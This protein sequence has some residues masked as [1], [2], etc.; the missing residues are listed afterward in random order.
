MHDMLTWV[1][2]WNTQ[3][4][5]S[6]VTY[7][8]GEKFV[9]TADV[10]LYAI[11]A[12]YEM[13][14]TGDVQ[15]F[16]TPRDGVYRLEVW[17]AEGGGS[18]P[19]K[20]GYSTTL[21]HLAEG[22]SFYVYVGEKPAN[23]T[24]IAGG[25][26]GGGSMGNNFNNRN[27]AGAGGGATDFRLYTDANDTNKGN[28]VIDPAPQAEPWK[29]LSGDP[30]TDPRILVAGGG[31]GS[32]QTGSSVLRIGGAGG[33]EVGQSSYGGTAS[34]YATGGTQT[35]GGN[36]Y[37]GYTIAANGEPGQ[38]SDG[39]ASNGFCRTGG[40]GGSGWWGGAGGGNSWSGVAD[41]PGGGGGSG[42]AG[43]TGQTIAGHDATGIPKISTHKGVDTGHAGHGYARIT[44]LGD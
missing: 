17:G 19:G 37:G 40:C 26:N 34:F 14:F 25:W 39:T 2:D 9:P 24:S 11:G 29:G 31:G 22:D 41:S 12:R 8:H 23:T 10:D 21:V 30:A 35:E 6:G 18:N 44:F 38:G 32:G 3:P 33:G 20:G 43:P 1:V 5:G 16:K 42:Y 13:P 27:G 36:S 15:T 7:W 4:D 28:V